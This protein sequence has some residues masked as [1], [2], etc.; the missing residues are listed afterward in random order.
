LNGFLW[1]EVKQIKLLYIKC[2]SIPS[3]FGEKEYMKKM[4]WNLF[5]VPGAGFI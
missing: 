5:S 2:K 4:M 3:F 1:I